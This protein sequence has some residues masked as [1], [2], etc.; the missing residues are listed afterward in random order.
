MRIDVLSGCSRKGLHADLAVAQQLA[1]RRASALT[2]LK[3]DFTVDDS[4]AVTFRA[5]DASP[6]IG[7]E[8]MDGLALPLRRAFQSFEIVD[9]D[10]GRRTLTQEAAIDEACRLRRKVAQV[11]VGLF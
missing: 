4:P 7:R 9:Y 2:V 5:L 1:R 10:I 3:C 8:I 11:V 6:L